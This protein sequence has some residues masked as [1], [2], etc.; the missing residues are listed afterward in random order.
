V[1]AAFVTRKG[2]PEVLEIRETTSPEPLPGEVR[3]Q[4]KAIGLNFADV[5][6]R[7]GV[8]TGTPKPPFVPGLEVSGIVEKTGGAAGDL[9]PG[10]RV[11]AVTRFGGH[12][13]QVVVPARRAVK[14]PQ[15]M[16]FA[17]GAAFPVN[18]LSAYHG[19]VTLAHIQPGE[20]L[21]LHAAAGG[22]G[23]ATIQL[24]RRLD[25]EVFGTAGTDEKVRLVLE[26]GAAHAI[27]YREEEFAPRVRQLTGGYGVDVV[28]DA[29]AGKVFE[30]SWRLLAPMGRYILFGMASVSGK[31]G[32]NYLRSAR[33]LLALP[34]IFPLSLVT[35]NKTI[36]GFH[37][38]LLHSGNRYLAAGMKELLSLYDAGLLRPLVGATFPFER[39]RDAHFHLQS[40]ASVGKVVV[41]V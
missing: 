19:I 41:E 7:L 2:G 38:G 37:L 25:A 24:A 28:M 11:M 20:R 23:I 26:Q 3:I 39:I 5:L 30:P 33:Q 1:L 14:M 27:N 9:E 17:E 13:E 21:L 16:P 6:A 22:V 29:V 35:A 8:Y 18:Y 10:D 31:G 32:L 34:R 12:A 40:R 15:G 36:A 4:V